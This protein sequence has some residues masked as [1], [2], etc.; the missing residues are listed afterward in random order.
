MFFENEPTRTL[1][2]I[3]FMLVV[4][5]GLAPVAL[6]IWM[7]L[8]LDRRRV[9]EDERDSPARADYQSR[10]AAESAVGISDDSAPP[11]FQFRQSRIVRKLPAAF[12]RSKP[13]GL[14]VALHPAA[15]RSIP[16]TEKEKT[17]ETA[18]C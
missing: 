16:K 18:I 1:T 3:E 13:L 14:F 8:V 11:V 9:A 7:K 12:D 2:L 10:Y 5:I 15:E 17:N 6:T 4:L